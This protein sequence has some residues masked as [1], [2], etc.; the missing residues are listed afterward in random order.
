MSTASVKPVVAPSFEPTY[1]RLLNAMPHAILLHGQPGIGLRTIAL[2]LAPQP[3][4][5]LL[6]KDAK[7]AIDRLKGSIGIEQVRTLY[8]QT[9]SKQSTDR[10]VIIVDA[11]S[12]GAP[13][14]NALLKLLEE[15]TATTKFILTAH[16]PQQL[17]PTIRS[18]VQSFYVPSITTAQTQKVIAAHT[19][20]DETTQKQL[21]FLANGRPALLDNLIRNPRIRDAMFTIAVDAKHFVESKSDYDRSTIALRHSTT[22]PD[23]IQ[24]ITAITDILQFS[25]AKHAALVNIAQLGLVLEAIEKLEQNHNVRLTMMHFVLQWKVK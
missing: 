7:G 23:A 13:A 19:K 17:L 25:I 22:K 3:L 6:P 1:I 16:Q 10:V 21:F 24:F 5:V 11:D 14:Q 2:S 18:R 20:L 15:P 12:M 8:E 4:A 9:R